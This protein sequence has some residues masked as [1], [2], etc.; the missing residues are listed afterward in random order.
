MKTKSN[1]MLI[2]RIKK[3]NEC[4]YSDLNRPP[5]SPPRMIDFM[6]EK[7]RSAYSCG[8]TGLILC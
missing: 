3:S 1:P 7:K 6:N 2:K 8:G 5:P 4:N